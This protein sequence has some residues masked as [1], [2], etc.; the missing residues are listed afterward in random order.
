M[1]NDDVINALLDKGASAS[2]VSDQIKDLLFAKSASRVDGMKP[3]VANS[4]FGDQ[5]AEPETD[6]ETKSEVEPEATNE[7]DQEEESND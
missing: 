3:S 6:T 5:E 1:P 4:M 7:V 2:E